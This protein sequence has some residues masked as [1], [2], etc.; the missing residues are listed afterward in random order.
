MPCSAKVSASPTEATVIP[1]APRSSCII[2]ISGDLWVFPCGRSATP[3][4]PAHSAARRR[5]RRS[6]TGS[7]R[8]EG[9][10]GT[11]SELLVAVRVAP[12]QPAVRPGQARDRG[13]L[14][15]AQLE[16]VQ[17]EVLLLPR[18]VA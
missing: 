1:T 15:V 11:G 7:T 2:A 10:A 16:A 17:V 18:G 4:A 13:H 6:R 3:F 9:A 12:E 5:F 8:R 14:L